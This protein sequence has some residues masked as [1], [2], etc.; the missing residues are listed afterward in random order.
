[1]RNRGEIGEYKVMFLNFFLLQFRSHAFQVCHC[2][3]K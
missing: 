2:A 1:M 3:S